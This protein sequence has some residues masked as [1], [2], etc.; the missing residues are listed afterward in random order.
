MTRGSASKCDLPSCR[1]DLSGDS[2][3]DEDET[4]KWGQE[5]GKKPTALS[6]GEGVEHRPGLGLTMLELHELSLLSKVGMEKPIADHVDQSSQVEHYLRRDK[7]RL[8]E[9][10]DKTQL[11]VTTETDVAGAHC[12]VCRCL[13]MKDVVDVQ[14]H[15]TSLQMQVSC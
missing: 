9:V 10:Y 2:T 14:V 13:C 6:P 7:G 1:S 12:L 4:C 8:R 3:E 5:H 11:E 15:Q